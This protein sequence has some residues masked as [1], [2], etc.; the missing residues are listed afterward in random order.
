MQQKFHNFINIFEGG[1]NASINLFN[2]EGFYWLTSAAAIAFAVEELLKY[3]DNF[4][5]IF[6]ESINPR[7]SEP[8]IKYFKESV[9]TGETSE[10]AIKEAQE[11]AL[12]NLEILVSFAK[13]FAVFE[14]IGGLV[15]GKTFATYWLI[16]KLIELEWQEILKLEEVKETYVLLDTVILDHRELEDLEEKCFDK[17]LSPDDQIYLE[18]HW[19]RVRF[20]WL[21]LY[22]DLQ[23]LKAGFIKFNPN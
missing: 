22:R 8:L 18:T 3:Q 15:L 5:Q 11:A 4:P 12:G 20:F 6:S 2:S 17:N 1:K 10:I 13:K 9:K 16:Y 19:E 23:L 14:P 7:Q 21:N